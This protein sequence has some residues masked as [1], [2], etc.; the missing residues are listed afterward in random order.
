M[1]ASVKNDS[2]MPVILASGCAGEVK[3]IGNK[4]RKHI[5]LSAHSR[6][7]IS[8]VVLLSVIHP[9]KKKEK[10][11]CSLE[12]NRGVYPVASCWEVQNQCG[13]KRAEVPEFSCE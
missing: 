10:F 2:C 11:R 6:A 9:G 1:R 4:C 7:S 12:L 3:V 8:C 5:E 13:K